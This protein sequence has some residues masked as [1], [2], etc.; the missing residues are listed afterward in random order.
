MNKDYCFSIDWLTVDI[1]CEDLSSFLSFFDRFIPGINEWTE[2]NPKRFYDYALNLNHKNIISLEYSID[3]DTN[4]V[5]LRAGVNHGILVN[6]SGDGLRL[7]GN[8]NVCKFIVECMDNWSC[9][10]TRV[11][12]ALDIYNKSNPIIPLLFEA[13]RN[14]MNNSLGVPR[15]VSRSREMKIFNNYDR[16]NKRIS[17]SATIGKRGNNY[18]RIYDKSLEQRQQSY[19]KGLSDN[20]PDYWYRIEIECRRTSRY[21]Y[22]DSVINSYLSGTPLN[23]IFS[24]QLQRVFRVDDVD[25]ATHPGEINIIWSEFLLD[26][27]QNNYFV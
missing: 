3:P 8:N 2:C 27:S 16:F 17:E 18:V 11:D 4:M 6:I 25:Y 23:D 15:L 5:D 10:W 13:V 1:M 24:A 19:N 7:M 26:I 20:I 21:E 22:G 9:H 12:L 14:R